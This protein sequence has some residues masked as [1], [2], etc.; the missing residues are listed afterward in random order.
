MFNVTISFSKQIFVLFFRQNEKLQEPDNKVVF[1][2]LYCTEGI[3]SDIGNAKLPVTA[4][5]CDWSHFVTD[6]S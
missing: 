5:S 6:F 1:W 3:I 2:M 4:N